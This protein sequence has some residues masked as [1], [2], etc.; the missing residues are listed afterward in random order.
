V[1]EADVGDVAA[2]GSADEAAVPAP[3]AAVVVAAVAAAA[4]D[5]RDAE[6][7]VAGAGTPEDVFAEHAEAAV[8][9][10]RQER[11][12]AKVHSALL[13]DLDPDLPAEVGVD[14]VKDV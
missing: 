10:V 4:G 9:S 7:A 11:I 5:I 12:I 13:E 2:S 1:A 3:A 8:S 14:N 6:T